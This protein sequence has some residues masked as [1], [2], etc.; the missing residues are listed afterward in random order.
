VIGDT[1]RVKSA[2]VKAATDVRHHHE[3]LAR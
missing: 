3:G 1:A 2:R